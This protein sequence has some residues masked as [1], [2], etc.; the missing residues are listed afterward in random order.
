M[1]AV[2]GEYRFNIVS[3]SSEKPAIDLVDTPAGIT[4]RRRWRGPAIREIAR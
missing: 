3:G 4:G 1:K 2:L